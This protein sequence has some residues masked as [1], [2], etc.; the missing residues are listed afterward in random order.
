[1]KCG[2]CGLKTNHPFGLY[3]DS[4]CICSGCTSHIQ[5]N[6]VMPK[7]HNCDWHDVKNKI[8]QNTG[9]DVKQCIVPLFFD[10]ETHYVI[11]ALTNMGIRPTVVY[12]N[13]LYHDNITFDYLS[14]IQEH[15][16]VDVFGINLPK[17][18]MK[19]LISNSITGSDNPRKFEI[20][21]NH[22]AALFF[23]E[24]MSIDLIVSGPLQ[25]SEIVGNISSNFPVNL[26]SAEFYDR[27]LV[28][29]FTNSD[30]AILNNCSSIFSKYFTESFIKKSLNLKKWIFLSDYIFWDSEEINTHYCQIKKF[31]QRNISGF[32][33]GWQ[34][35]SSSI[36]LEEFDLLRK[37][38]TSSSKIDSY[39][40]R[41]IRFGRLTLEEAEATSLLYSKK[42]WK[43]DRLSDF[44][45]IERDNLASALELVMKKN[46]MFFNISTTDDRPPILS[47][48]QTIM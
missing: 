2:K 47:H 6:S 37:L 25:S 13:S 35:T 42:Y 18:T 4:N 12:F 29:P 40:A 17:Q 8:T 23:A 32:N 21:G 48:G 9:L 5:R 28:S 22:L 39:L 19:M 20:F 43:I 7:W 10:N 41:D 1:M 16:S 44:L 3:L 15:F 31:C 14:K 24:K 38:T 27:I 26:S 34:A 36:K 46:Q 11:E 30:M 45:E 33:S